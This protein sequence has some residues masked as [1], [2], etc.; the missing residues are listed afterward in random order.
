MSEPEITITHNRDES[1]YEV[2]V[3]GTLAGRMEYRDDGDV[4]VF[5][6]TEVDQEIGVKGLASRMAAYAL[7]DV[8]ERGA[9]LV[10][11]C[12]FVRTWIERHPDYA[13]LVART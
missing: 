2:S 10:P 8:R 3:D 5:T 13:D 9:R 7:D 6:H 1:R 12:S 11:E 4:L